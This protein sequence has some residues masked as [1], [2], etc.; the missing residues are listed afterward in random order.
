VRLPPPRK[1]LWL[2]RPSPSPGD[3]K[4]AGFGR[5]GTPSAAQ[6]LVYAVPLAC[7]LCGERLVLVPH[8]PSAV[9]ARSSVE[10]TS[11]LAIHV[12]IAGIYRSIVPTCRLRPAALG[13]MAPSSSIAVRRSGVEAFGRAGCQS[14]TGHL[15]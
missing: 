8:G 14:A 3:R 4:Q 13:A 15:D 12:W 5:Y 9:G 10:R 6:V 11:H 7:R 2:F 1:D